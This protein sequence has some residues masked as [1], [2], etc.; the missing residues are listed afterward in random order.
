[1]PSGWFDFNTAHALETGL[2]SL[3]QANDQA[4]PQRFDYQKNE[5]RVKKWLADRS[6]L[7]H[8]LLARVVVMVDFG[9]LTSVARSV[10]FSRLAEIA[11]ALEA[12]HADHQ[13]Y[14]DDL[15]RLVPEYLPSVPGDIDGEPIRYALDPGNGRYRLWSVGEDGID[16]GGVEEVKPRHQRS[17]PRYWFGRTDDW[18]WQYPPR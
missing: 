4:N 16:N 5:I 14:P 13:S 7:G 18:V 6:W 10:I 12:F 9:G 15:E 1:M 3:R 11:C 17:K 2:I 8:T